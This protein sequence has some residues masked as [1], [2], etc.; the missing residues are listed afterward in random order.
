MRKQLTIN[1][2][3]RVNGVG[4]GT[5]LHHQDGQA[6][7]EMKPAWATL[8]TADLRG[9]KCYTIATNQLRPTRLGNRNL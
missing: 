8:N 1:N 9:T 3:Y 2:V 4:V 7:V 5:L 6:F